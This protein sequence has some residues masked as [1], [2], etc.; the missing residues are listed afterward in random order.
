[1]IAFD[2]H[3]YIRCY[4]IKSF[5]HSSFEIPPV[6]YVRHVIIIPFSLTK[7]SCFSFGFQKCQ[8]ISFTHWTFDVSDELSILFVQEFHFDLCTLS[9]R[10][11]PAKDLYHSRSNYRFL[12]ALSY[13]SLCNHT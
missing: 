3:R 7:S 9:L 1:M 4:N 8:N 6:L 11:G 12:H 5:R 13:I 2:S 10:P